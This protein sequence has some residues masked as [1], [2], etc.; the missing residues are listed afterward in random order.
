M[1]SEGTR[2]ISLL[3]ALSHVRVDLQDHEPE[4]KDNDFT[5]VNFW[6]EMWGSLCLNFAIV[7]ADDDKG[8]DGGDEDQSRSPVP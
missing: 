7:S 5:T 2:N 8:G 4:D 6:P 3:Q 1:V